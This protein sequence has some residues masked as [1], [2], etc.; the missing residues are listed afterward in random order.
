MAA[1]I[2]SGV[3]AGARAACVANAGNGWAAGCDPHVPGTS[4]GTAEL[5]RDALQDLLAR[6]GTFLDERAGQLARDVLVARDRRLE[7]LHARLW[8]GELTVALA[9]AGGRRSARAAARRCRSGHAAHDLLE[10]L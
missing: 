9:R 3:P 5:G 4:H 7:V 6:G 8:G 2:A 1:P 10:L